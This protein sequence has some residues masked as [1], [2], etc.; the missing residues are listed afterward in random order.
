MFNSNQILSFSRGFDCGNF[1]H[2][3]ENNEDFQQ[4]LESQEINSD[5]FT[6]EWLAGACFGWHSSL[7]D[8]EIYCDYSLDIL[9]DSGNQLL[10]GQAGI[11]NR[12]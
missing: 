10:C 7:E 11:V 6:D 2:A 4:W 1:G 8:S 9:Q 5:K 3:Y 12:V